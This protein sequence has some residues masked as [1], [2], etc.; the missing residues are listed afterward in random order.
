[1]TE[2]M[3]TAGALESAEARN[4]LESMP[5]INDLMPRITLPELGA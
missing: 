3:I 2:T 4:F 5:S 1:M